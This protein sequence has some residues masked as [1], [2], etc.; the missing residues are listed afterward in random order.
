MEKV[1]FEKM[2]DD[3]ML[4]G[5]IAVVKRS[6]EA[7]AELLAYL[8]EVERRG[9]QLREAC[10]SMFAFCTERLHLSESA[11]GKRITAARTARRFPIVLDMIAS[12]EIHLAAV[13]LL[14]AHLTERN[15]VALLGGGGTAASGGREAGRRDRAAA[16]CGIT[17]GSAAA[18][19]SRGARG[20]RGGR[21]ELGARGR[22]GGRF[23]LAACARRAR[24]DYVVARPSRRRCA[25]LVEDGV[26]G[27]RRRCECRA[28]SFDY[29]R[30]RRSNGDPSAAPHSGRRGGAQPMAEDPPGAC[31]GCRLWTADTR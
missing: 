5:V 29:S 14:A 28:V 24:P 19:V 4:E 18:T 11:A 8:I 21:F 6:N 31:R 26:S 27:L 22:R 9:L 1:L 7:T 25:F 10:S 16:G 12:G 30:S 3:R 20:R 15:H 13:N 2:D 23:E 17:S